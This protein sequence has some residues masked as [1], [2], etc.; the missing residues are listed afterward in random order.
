MDSESFKGNNEANAAI[1]LIENTN[2]SLFLTG[3]AGTGKSTLLNHI[4]ENSKKEFIKLAPTGVAAL[5]IGGQTIHRFFGLHIRPFIPYDKNLGFKRFTQQICNKADTFIIDEVSMVRADVMT[6]IDLMLRKYTGWKNLPFGGKQLLLVGDLYQLPP[7]VDQNKPEEVEIMETHYP[8]PF[9]FGAHNFDEMNI[10]MI[11]LKQ[12]YRQTDKEFV[13]ILDKIRTGI[14]SQNE[15]NILNQRYKPKNNLPHYLDKVMSLTP[16]SN[17]A[18]SINNKILESIN[19]SLVIFEA[20][21]TGTFDN[22]ST[23]K[24]TPQSK[25][26]TERELRLKKDARVMFLTNYYHPNS[27]RPRWVNGTLGTVISINKNS[28]DVRLDNGEE[29]NV[30]LHTWQDLKYQWNSKTNEIETKVIG[31]F[32]QLPIKLAW[33]STIHKSQGLTLE[34]VNIDFGR[35]AFAE[36]QAYVALSRCTSYDGLTLSSQLSMSDIKVSRDAVNFMKSYSG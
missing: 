5:N 27:N 23:Q 22:N 16:R 36:G 19:S 34:N 29:E 17:Q 4:I 8:N 3:K 1:D 18:N 9:F 7:I 33:A 30:G 2:D 20:K 11:E 28:I 25:P 32:C 6:A 31:T 13:A 10:N 26:P 24:G 14:A 21:A 15:L 35:G 12:V